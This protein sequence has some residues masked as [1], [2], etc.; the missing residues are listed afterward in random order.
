M[1]LRRLF[2]LMAALVVA[3]CS[4]LPPPDQPA[5]PNRIGRFIG[6]IANC[7]CSDIGPERMLV[8]YPRA[9]AD[10]YSAAE[11]KSMHGY[12]DVGAYERYANQIVICRAACSN[13]CMV[14]SVVAPLGG[15]LAG[16]GR[17]CPITERDLHLTEGVTSSGS[18]G[19]GVSW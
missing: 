14:N 2:A 16:D 19:A 5:A 18:D 11:I 10:R 17:S 8:E 13:T 4:L 7:G 12:V 9:V 1:M 15:K 6:L 3:S